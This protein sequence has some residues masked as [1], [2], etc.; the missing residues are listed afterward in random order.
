MTSISTLVSKKNIYVAFDIEKCGRRLNRKDPLFA[1]GIVVASAEDNKILKTYRCILNL[2]KPS[3]V[4][5]EEYWK[6]ND[7]ELRCWLTCWIKLENVLDDLQS[8]FAMVET[9]HE[10]ANEFNRVLTEIEDEY[11]VMA[12]VFNTVTFDSVHLSS[13]LMEYD[14]LPLNYRRDG[15]H[16]CAFEV[17]SIK[18]GICQS[19]KWEYYDQFEKYVLSHYLPD[20]GDIKHDHDPANDAATIM[21][22]FL[23]CLNYMRHDNERMTKRKFRK[24]DIDNRSKFLEK[25]ANDKESE[26]TA[27]ETI[28]NDLYL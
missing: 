12:F 17:D 20:I 11:F 25:Y 23:G 2:K 26:F 4:S 27:A 19:M 13:L 14:H 5:W 1:I 3:D 6:L 9:E 8:K 15:S 22:D 7:W 28:L 21:A 18:T 24:D 16:L 10:L